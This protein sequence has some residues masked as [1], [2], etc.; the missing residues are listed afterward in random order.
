MTHVMGTHPLKDAALHQGENREKARLNL[1]NSLQSVND[2][3]SRSQ[4]LRFRGHISQNAPITR[5]VSAGW[6]GDPQREGTTQQ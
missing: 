4:T 6:G 2:T 5:A 1:T 3:M